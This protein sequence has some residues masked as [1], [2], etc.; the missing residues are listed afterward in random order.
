MYLPIADVISRLNLDTGYIS[1]GGCIDFSPV[2][3]KE[4]A[5]FPF[6]DSEQVRKAVKLSVQA[7]T[8]WEN[9]SPDVKTDLIR[10]FANELRENTDDLARL[11]ATET[12][13]IMTDAL[14]EVKKSIDVCNYVS[15]LPQ[16]LTGLSAPT[17]SN[18]LSLME[19]WLPIG[20]VAVI[21]PFNLP[22]RVWTLH[23]MLALACG[24]PV[25]WRPSRKTVLTAFA[26][27]SLLRRAM[28]KLDAACPEYL[29]QLIICDRKDAAVFAENP[30]VALLCATGSP[31]NVRTLAATTG[32]RGGRSLISSGGNNSAVI[33]PDAD[34]DAAVKHLVR[35]TII[36]C[37]Q[38]CTAFQRLFCHSSVYDEVVGKLKRGLELIYVNSPFERQTEIGP[39]IDKESFDAMNAALNAAKSEG[40]KVFGGERLLIGGYDNAYYVHPALV[41]MPEQTDTVKKELLAPVLFVMKYDSLPDAVSR[42][43]EVPKSLIS[44]IFSNNIK[45][46]GYFLSVNGV[47]S[48]VATVNAGSVGYDLVAMFGNNRSGG[49]SSSEIWH[50]YMRSKT[51]LINYNFQPQTCCASLL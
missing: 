27:N 49:S 38:Q 42:V 2:N 33:T 28:A 30:D 20:P 21:T 6:H 17:E 5:S 16:R 1:G 22:L 36:D 4:I 25:I 23:A 44:A 19:T 37:G 41:E 43:N 13:K 7:F 48:N 31:E 3:G 47:K 8:E 34:I 9:V 35:G 14:R 11:I 50:S 39:L 26:A 51:C 46:T 29:S 10:T 45:E 32:A 15:S 40:G 18:G 24:N 12:G